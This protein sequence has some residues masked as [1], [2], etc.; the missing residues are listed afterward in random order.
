MEDKV[1]EVESI[2]ICLIEGPVAP[3]KLVFVRVA[4]TKLAFVHK[5]VFEKHYSFILYSII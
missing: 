5:Y 1:N 4:I 3:V 2:L